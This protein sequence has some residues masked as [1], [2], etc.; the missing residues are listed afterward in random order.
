MFDSHLIKSNHRVTRKNKV[1][2]YGAPVFAP[3]HSAI[4]LAAKMCIN[5]HEHSMYIR[6]ICDKHI[7]LL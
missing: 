3:E 1:D 7:S 6:F 4:A 2:T 5:F